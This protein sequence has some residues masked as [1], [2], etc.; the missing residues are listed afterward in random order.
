MTRDVWNI[1]EQEFPGTFPIEV[2]LRFL[3]RF[4]ILAPSTR[5]TQPWRLEVQGNTVLLFAGTKV[6]RPTS[7]PDDRE[8]YLSLGCALE[9]LLVAAEHFGLVHDV[10]YFPYGTRSDLAARIAFQPGRTRSR[11]R[12]GI[13]LNA[14][15]QRHNDNGLYRSTPL[16]DHVRGRLQ[17]CCAESELRLDLTHNQFFRRRIEELTVEADRIEFA[18]PEFRRELASWISQGA[19]GTSR[20]VSRLEGLAVSR[21]NLGEAM[22]EQD[23]QLLKSA[24]LLGLISATGDSHLIHVKAG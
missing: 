13:T 7:D 15:L 20:V 16:P 5:N 2:Q 22:A 3:L 24:A 21:L 12:A 23:R 4:A 17:A 1:S 18:N 19:F 6:P 9:N 10:T 14:I 11:V 8:L